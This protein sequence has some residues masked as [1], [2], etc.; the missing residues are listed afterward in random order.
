MRVNSTDLFGSTARPSKLSNKESARN[1]RIRKKLYIELLEAKISQL[2]EKVQNLECSTY[3]H[4]DRPIPSA[5]LG[6]DNS[7]WAFQEFMN[8]IR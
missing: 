2:E 5:F 8:S 4:D 7:N 6:G 3:N 1:S